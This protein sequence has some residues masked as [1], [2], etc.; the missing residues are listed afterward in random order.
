MQKLEKKRTPQSN[1]PR[2]KR[3][4]V[5]IKSQSRTARPYKGAKNAVLPQINGGPSIISAVGNI[6]I[7]ARIKD[8]EELYVI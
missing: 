2:H 3:G 7:V 4:N 8:D 6:R 5:M 1:K